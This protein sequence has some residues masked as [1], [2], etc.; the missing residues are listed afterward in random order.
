MSNFEFPAYTIFTGL[1]LDRGSIHAVK[2][3]CW[4]DSVFLLPRTTAH[5]ASLDW[6]RMSTPDEITFEQ[7]F[8]TLRYL[9]QHYLKV[10][11]EINEYELITGDYDSRERL[12]L[13]V[14]PILEKIE[15]H[16]AKL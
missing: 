6:E 14:V 16:L 10:L 12:E 3:G 8:A 11:V 5:A 9:R 7:R 15:S 1:S 13:A 2:Y 4:L